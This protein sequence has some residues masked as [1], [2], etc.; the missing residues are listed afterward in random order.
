LAADPGKIQ[1]EMEKLG[2][3]YFL[4]SVQTGE[5]IESLMEFIKEQVESD[6]N[7]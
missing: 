2:Q 6:R 5:G 1:E 7:A 4:I 3:L